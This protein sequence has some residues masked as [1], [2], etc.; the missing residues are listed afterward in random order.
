[1]TASDP[2]TRHQSNAVARVQLE[3][4]V[5]SEPISGYVQDHTG[6]HEF[7]GWIDLVDAIAKAHET[8]VAH[9]VVQE[10]GAV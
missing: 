8:G 7:V 6:R 10:G 5:G 3:L 4:A 2:V 1:M 9:S